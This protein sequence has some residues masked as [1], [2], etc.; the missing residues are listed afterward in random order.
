MREYVISVVAASIL[1][2]LSSFVSYGRGNER[3]VRAAIAMILIYTVCMPVLRFTS[4][5]DIDLLDAVYNELKDL[6]ELAPMEFEP[7]TYERSNP[8]EF[9][10]VRDDDGS[11][12]VIGP[13]VDLLS[14]NVVLNDTDSLAYF[15]KTLREKGVIKQLRKC[16]VQDGDTVV[17]GEVEFD[18]VD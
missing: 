5:F 4:E 11:Y 15:Q 16:G 7:F 8:D 13:L 2:A 14:R 1:C 3:A 12:V 18:F 9:E 10:I 17:I 6:P